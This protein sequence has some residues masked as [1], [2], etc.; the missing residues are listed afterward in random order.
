MF[1]FLRRLAGVDAEAAVK[2]RNEQLAAL[3]KQGVELDKL[4]AK[5]AEARNATTI[6]TEVVRKETDKLRLS[7]SSSEYRFKLDSQ[8]LGVK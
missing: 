6:R 2:I 1:T 5:M 8:P 7:T 3:D 4:M